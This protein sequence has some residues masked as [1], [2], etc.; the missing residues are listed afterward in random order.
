MESGD[1]S[2]MNAAQERLVQAS[3]KLA[4]EMYKAA[5]AQTPPPGSG[6]SA[7]PQSGEKKDN[8]VDAEF[9]DVDEGKK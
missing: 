6:P 3:H 1:I 7:G 4:E 5:S 2:R 9:V 8:V